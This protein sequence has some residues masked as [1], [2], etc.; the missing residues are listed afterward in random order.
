M[1][2]QANEPSLSWLK[3]AES[4]ANVALEPSAFPSQGTS[5]RSLVKTLNLQKSNQLLLLF[6]RKMQN[7][8]PDMSLCIF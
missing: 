4:H 8:Q 3:P 1:P 5:S 2:N 6:M 7:T